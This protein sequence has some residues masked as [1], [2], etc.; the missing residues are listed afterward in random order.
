M[1]LLRPSETR[2]VPELFR[3]TLMML[4]FCYAAWAGATMGAMFAIATIA[5]AETRAWTARF[6][7]MTGKLR[8]G[9]APVRV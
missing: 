4:P 3:A 1:D 9:F 8:L 2:S 5:V 7:V 6:N